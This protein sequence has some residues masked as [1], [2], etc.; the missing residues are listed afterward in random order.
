[1]QTKVNW[2]QVIVKF[3]TSALS[4]NQTV[5]LDSMRTDFILNIVLQYLNEKYLL[6]I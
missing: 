1:M 2:Y 5:L 3:N 6:I 4:L